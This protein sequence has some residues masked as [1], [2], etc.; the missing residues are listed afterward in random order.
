MFTRAS[1]HCAERIVA[2]SSS[3]A[4][5][6]SSAQCASGYAALQALQDL[7]PRRAPRSP[8]PPRGVDGPCAHPR[9]PARG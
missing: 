1:V 5:R 3:K 7:E 6:W 4:F 8:R 9:L 2:Q